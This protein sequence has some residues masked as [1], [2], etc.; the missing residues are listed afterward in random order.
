LIEEPCRT[1]K[2]TREKTALSDEEFDKL[3]DAFKM[4]EG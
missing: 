1:G 4:T 3:L 2:A